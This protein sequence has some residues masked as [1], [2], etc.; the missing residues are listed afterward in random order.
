MLET[1]LFILRV[2]RVQ[3]KI[4]RNPDATIF[5]G[6]STSRLVQTVFGKFFN[7]ETICSFAWI[8]LFKKIS[9]SRGIRRVEIEILLDFRVS[10]RR[11]FKFNPRRSYAI[12]ELLK[13]SLR[14]KS[15]SSRS[16][17]HLEKHHRQWHAICSNLLKSVQRKE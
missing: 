14:F 1:T 15:V 9:L 7:S 5:E 6:S 8:Q 10:K 17:P 3:Y 11:S 16:K 4:Q 13:L 2:N 12:F